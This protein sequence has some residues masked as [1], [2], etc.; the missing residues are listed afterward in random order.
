MK[1]ETVDQ[2]NLFHRE[3]DIKLFGKPFW[4]SNIFR[5]SLRVSI[6]ILA[7]Y[8]IA[9]FF[10]FGHSYWILLTIVTI[11]KPAYGL[12]K[13]RN[14]ERLMGTLAG[15][16]LGVLLLSSV[17]NNSV[18]FVFL[19]LSMIIGYSFLQIRYVVS[20]VGITLY[21]LL[22]FH[23]LIPVD[24][25][26]LSMDRVIDTVIGSVISFVGALFIFP[27][28]EQ[29][30][31]HEYVEKTEWKRIF[32]ILLLY[33]AFYQKPSEIN[34]YKISGKMHTWHWQIC[35]MYFSDCCLNPKEI[36]VIPKYSTSL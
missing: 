17:H 8:I 11:L 21:V 4:K 1:L 18:L 16:G 2:K 10:P 22:F 7:G 30:Q 3:M 20:V 29:E 33:R 34:T 6:C 15:A 23:F 28:W 13:K 35:R 36:L 31:A 24:F 14:I 32:I 12:T 27:K 26:L 19:I 9:Q 25:R 5:H